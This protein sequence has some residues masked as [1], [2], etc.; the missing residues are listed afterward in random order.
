MASK[1]K[2]GGNRRYQNE[3]GTLTE[4]GKRR[5]GYDKNTGKISK[6]GEQLIKKDRQFI[7]QYMNI[8]NKALIDYNKDYNKNYVK[9]YNKSSGYMNATGIRKFNKEQEKKYGKEY[10]KRKGY[11]S[12]YYKI[13]NKLLNKN[14][15]DV[16]SEWYRNNKNFKAAANLI[17]KYGEDFVEDKNDIKE[18]KKH[19]ML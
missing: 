17:K 16:M 11:E 4:E 3:D 13:F 5:Y 18:F 8:R 7:K 12:D 10:Y 6:A 1:D 19:K 14:F 2:N 15:D 9:A